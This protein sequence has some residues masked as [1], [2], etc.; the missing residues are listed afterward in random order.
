[1]QS[2]KIGQRKE[3][4]T[5]A[6]QS[7]T[8]Q[9]PEELIRRMEEYGIA[10]DTAY[11][12]RVIERELKQQQVVHDIR[13]TMAVLQEIPDE[14]KPSEAEILAEIKAVRAERRAQQG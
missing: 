13:E 6:L 14:D 1:M 7:F 12:E 10:E 2:D 3:I 5:M 11:W 8:I 9:L 4:D